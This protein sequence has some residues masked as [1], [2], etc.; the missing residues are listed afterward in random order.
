MNPLTTPTV[1]LAGLWLIVRYD[2]AVERRRVRREIAA[3]T[4]QAN[5]DAVAALFDRMDRE[6]RDRAA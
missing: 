5:T 6:E 1:C 3:R 4:A 2:R